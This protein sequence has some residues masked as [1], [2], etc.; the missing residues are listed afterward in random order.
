[1]SDIPYEDEKQ[2]AQWIHELFQRKVESLIVIFNYKSS[3]IDFQDQIYEYFLQHDQ[4][5]LSRLTLTRNYQDLF[6]EIFWLVSITIPS[7]IYFIEF[8]F[9]NSLTIKCLFGIIFFISYMIIQWM[10]NQ[11]VIKNK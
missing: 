1:M 7:L 6:I 5:N 8:F 10:I 2:S 4:F 3:R 11:S 9:Y